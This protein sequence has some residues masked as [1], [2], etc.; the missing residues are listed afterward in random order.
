[1]SLIEA[2][3]IMLTTWSITRL[4]IKDEFPPVRIVRDWAIATFGVVG[5]DGALVGGRAGWGIVGWS[6][7]YLWTCFWCMSVWVAGILVALALT[8]RLDVMMI[9]YVIFVARGAAGLLGMIEAR[10]DQ[11]YEEAQRRLDSPERWR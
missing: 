4:L 8:V 1:M 7:A 6:I 3:A 9:V 5:K 11:S 2:V 10:V